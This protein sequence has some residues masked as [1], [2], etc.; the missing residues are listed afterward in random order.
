MGEVINLIN[1][2]FVIN[3]SKVFLSVLVP[4]R[5]G[6]CNIYEIKKKAQRCFFLKP[7][8]SEISEKKM[9]LYNTYKIQNTNRSQLLSP[10]KYTSRCFVILT[11]QGF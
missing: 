7:W 2:K 4:L 1:Q 5:W 8:M 6:E 9:D 11:S 3:K 10:R